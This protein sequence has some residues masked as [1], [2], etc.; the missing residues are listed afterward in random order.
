MSDPTVLVTRPGASPRRATRWREGPLRVPGVRPATVAPWV[1]L[2]ALFAIYASLQPNVLA[3]DEL[4]QIAIGGLVLVLVSAGQTVVV[5][6]GGIDLSVGGMMAF[7]T[8]VLATRMTS[9]S[10]AAWILIVLA[11]GA[12]GG[13][14]NG[15]IVAKIGMQPFIATLGTWSI[16][17]GAALLVLPT[18]GGSVPTEFSNF[19][20]G[21]VFGL[22]TSIALIIAVA[23][24]WLWFRRTR[25][26]RRA[27]AI[28]SSEESSYLSGVEITRTKLMVYAL[29]GLAAMAAAV[30]YTM[31]TNSGDPTSGDPFILTSVAAVV[32]GG[33]SL[34]G[35]RGGVGGTIAGALVL[36]LIA[37]VVFVLGLS[38]FWTPALQGVLLILAVTVGAVAS[39]REARKAGQ[40]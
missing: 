5:L 10:I 16:L 32:L 25:F 9:G 34:F 26:A 1:I 6:T 28:G 11:I 40:L 3:L 14:V 20:Y 27:Y 33:T 8:T 38:A 21:S 13:A 31:Q 23:I 35:G 22:P 12:A 30:I 39:K 4:G 24:A 19:I 17:D 29:S 18:Q 37:D 7:G 36:T 2:A 15:L